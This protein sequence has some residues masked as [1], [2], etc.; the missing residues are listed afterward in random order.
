MTAMVLLSQWMES[1]VEFW[2]PVPEFP[3]YD[4][5]SNGQLRTYYWKSGTGRSFTNGQERGSW[6]YVIKSTPQMIGCSFDKDGYRRAVLSRDGKGHA[7]RVHRLV[8]QAFIPNERLDAVQINH[9]NNVHD[10]NRLFN[11][12]WCTKKENRDHAIAIGVWPKGVQHG[13]TKIT[14]RQVV[15]I[16]ARVA[17]GEPKV[18]IASD[19]GITA[20][21]VWRIEKR[22]VWR[23]VL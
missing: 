4:V 9:L 11:L 7:K 2:K 19:Y 13:G 6:A 21:N 10:D 3:A 23:E 18:S 1:Q 20:S 16:R 17:S 22:L 15:E 8:A 5:S 12:E 14:E